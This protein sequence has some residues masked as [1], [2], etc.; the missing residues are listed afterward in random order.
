MECL[1]VGKG[2]TAQWV[3]VLVGGY[4]GVGSLWD[5]SFDC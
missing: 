2:V 5:F 4:I 3:Y 1:S